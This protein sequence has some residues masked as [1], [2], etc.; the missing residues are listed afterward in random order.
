MKLN[1]LIQTNGGQPYGKNR[2]ERGW[3]ER[4]E[5]HDER[6]NEVWSDEEVEK[7]AGTGLQGK[8]VHE[9]GMNMVHVYSST[10]GDT[11]RISSLQRQ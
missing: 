6:S 11:R 9:L 2:R 7:D 1:D 3:E 8:G 10:E 5:K 4:H